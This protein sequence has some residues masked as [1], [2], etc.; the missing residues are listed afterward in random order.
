MKVLEIGIEGGRVTAE[1]FAELIK[2][3]GENYVIAD[4]ETLQN[5]SHDETELLHFFT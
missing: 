1:I 2:I 5:Y 4:E 3:L